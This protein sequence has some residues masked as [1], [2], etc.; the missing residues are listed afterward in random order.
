MHPDRDAVPPSGTPR[1]HPVPKR[2]KNLGSI[3]PGGS[4]G[5]IVTWI[6]GESLADDPSLRRG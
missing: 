4:S 1:L 5:S 3:R 6:S 2:C